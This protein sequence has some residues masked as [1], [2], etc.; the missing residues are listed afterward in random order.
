[1]D[2]LYA[3]GSLLTPIAWLQI[4]GLTVAG[5]YLALAIVSARRAC[6]STRYR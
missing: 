5:A 3:L 4:G 2:T 1:M 6:R